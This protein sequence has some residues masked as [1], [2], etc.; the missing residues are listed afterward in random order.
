MSEDDDDGFIGYDETTVDPGPWIIVATAL[1]CVLSIV[2]FPCLIAL[3]RRYERRKLHQH[4]AEHRDEHDSNIEQAPVELRD[5]KNQSEARS[6]GPSSYVHEN[7]AGSRFSPYTTSEPKS[8]SLS[9]GAEQAGR[10]L[11]ALL[12]KLVMPPYPGDFGSILSIATPARMPGR[13]GIPDNVVSILDTG[14]AGLRN[15]PAGVRRYRC[16]LN[17]KMLEQEQLMKK[18]LELMNR[19][20]CDT[21]HASSKK[22][23]QQRGEKHPYCDDLEGGSKKDDAS[24]QRLQPENIPAREP[25]SPKSLERAEFLRALPFLP[26]DPSDGETQGSSQKILQSSFLASDVDEI[27]VT[28]SSLIESVQKTEV[29]PDDAVDAHIPGMMKLYEKVPMEGDNIDIC[30]GE[31]AWWRPSTIAAGF[32]RLLEIAEWDKEMKRIVS[33]AIPFSLAAVSRGAFETVRVALVA[34]FIGTDA[35]GAY[36]I[37]LIVLG[38]TQ[39]FFGGFALTNSS[40]CSHAVGAGNDY[41]A[42]QY[43]QISCILLSLFMIPNVLLWMFLTDDV[44]RLF[45][46]NEAACKMAQDYARFLVLKHWIQGFDEAY[47]SL[48]CVIDHERFYTIMSIGNEIVATCIILGL[49]VTRPTSLGQVG[50]VEL[51]SRAFFFGL[52]LSITNWSGWMKKYAK[53][54]FKTNALRNIGAVKTVFKTAVPLAF[55]QLLQYGE[56][57][58]LTIFVA[59]LGPAEVTTWG[60]IGSLW[61]TLEMLTEGFG[62]AGE[63]RTALHLGAARPAT[64]RLSAYK[65]MLVAIICATLF[66]SLVWILGEDL[67]SWMTPDPTLQRLIIEVLPLLGLG[68]IALTT[69]SVSWALVGAQGRYRLATLVAFVSSW[70]VTLPLAAMATYGLKID[71]QGTVSSVVIGYT[72]AGTCLQYILVRSDWERL[73]KLV[74]EVNG[75]IESE[76]ESDSSSSTS[77]KRAKGDES[78]SLPTVA[79]S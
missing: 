60:I 44:V 9:A 48:V 47:G 1:F 5:G 78:P 66:T 3:G 73:S 62:D 65:T 30:C 76:E 4:A 75:G 49:V 25:L 34:N 26:G 72:F 42:G 50:L 35:V 8:L 53:G 45:G 21:M 22:G 31:Q 40:L 54:M 41:Q 10:Q 32:D 74:I 24:I 77:S 14:G 33:L 2:L 7:S 11:Q 51:V 70:C 63:F 18:R 13:P 61:D 59:A 29:L 57:E 56:W 16:G 36:T 19:P 6:E 69:G 46:F 37:V 39:E 27:S 64:A 12:D 79:G 20:V 68:N 52:L 71:L 43:V 17:E 55:G 58:V 28:A 67:A 15:R 23:D 38:L